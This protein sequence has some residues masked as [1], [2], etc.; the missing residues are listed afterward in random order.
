MFK[1]FTYPIT[2]F[3]ACL[4]TFHQA[5]NA[6][7]FWQQFDGLKAVSNIEG[8][9]VD[10]NG[11]LHIIKQQG[12][13][14]SKDNGKTWIQTSTLR[15]GINNKFFLTADGKLYFYRDLDERL[16]NFDYNLENWVPVS[17][18]NWGIDIFDVDFSGKI[19][20]V[21]GSGN[22]EIL[23]SIDGGKLYFPFEI[24]QVDGSGL[25]NLSCLNAQHNLIAISNGA[26]DKLYH[27]DA[28]GNTSF[29]H[30]S[31]P[32][33]FIDYNP[34]S[35]TAFFC[36]SKKEFF[37][38]TNGG[39]D[40]QLIKIDLSQTA[41]PQIR[42]LDFSPDGKIWATN[43][44][45]IFLSEDDGATWQKNNFPLPAQGY[46]YVN[47]FKGDL[48]F[49]N[50]CVYPNFAI[51]MDGGKIWQNLT[52]TFSEPWVKEVQTLPNDWLIAKTCTRDAFEKSTDNGT[53]WSDFELPGVTPV[54]VQQIAS[55]KSGQTIAIGSNQ[56]IYKAQNPSMLIWELVETHPD[57][58]NLEQVFTDKTGNFYL[59][60]KNQMLKSMDYGTTWQLLNID[61]KNPYPHDDP[62]F[63]T[64][65]GDFY[66]INGLSQLIYYQASTDFAL[67]IPVEFDGKPFKMYSHLYG[68]SSDYIFFVAT[69]P[70][71]PNYPIHF[72]RM[73]RQT[74]ELERLTTLPLSVRDF[75]YFDSNDKDLL[76]AVSN[77]S[78]PT[79]FVSNDNAETWQ[80]L[81]SLPF[82]NGI[83]L[84]EITSTGRLFVDLGYASL[85]GSAELFTS[86]EPP[87]S[88]F[89]IAPRVSPNPFDHD[90]TIEF[91]EK[92]HPE[93]AKITLFDILGKEV[94]QQQFSFPR[95]QFEC[96][97]LPMGCYFYKITDGQRLFA[98]GKIFKSK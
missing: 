41:Q 73:S 57:I 97:D 24:G 9:T 34:F 61:L 53:T 46:I 29:V 40:W 52:H 3:L 26:L 64:P 58:G 30:Q 85:F 96:P 20:A 98:S 35:Q 69:N 79:I 21:K 89:E 38:S 7:S 74:H 54:F 11:N 63:F 66:F 19:Y 81:P 10:G 14:I 94:L 28:N 16:Y 50:S 60:G 56:K 48:F 12:T 83:S 87:A 17:Y 65:D 36:N 27:F 22:L 8:F 33:Y 37:R 32:I 45:H 72:V 84:F 2:L 88:P 55:T 71:D 92:N 42:R 44:E 67:T 51:S 1:I 23:R 47:P 68:L 4:F 91:L 25:S 31:S 82:P 78:S 49:S 13:F 77:S 86:T 93:K 70:N 6:Q 90:F 62:F 59:L 15:A 95:D 76:F 75:S 43:N 5:S 39:L 18:E 80:P